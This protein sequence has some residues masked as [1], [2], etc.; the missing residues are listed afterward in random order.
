MDGASPEQPPASERR[1]VD[2]RIRGIVQGVG[3]RPHIW[4][5]AT[6]LSLTGDV[7]ND[8]GGV[9]IR[10]AGTRGSVEALLNSIRTE[11]PHTARI[12][13]IDVRDIDLA[14]TPTGFSIADS[15]SDLAAVTFAP[16]LATCSAC[17]DEIRDPGQRRFRYPFTNCTACGP[18]LTIVEH[19]PYD[20]ANTT[21]RDFP[22]CAAC[23]TEY[24]LP[25]DRRYH[26]EPIACPI[27][28][29]RL[30]LTW[31]DGRLVDQSEISGDAIT[32]AARLLREGHILAIKGLGGFHLACDATLETAIIALRRRKRRVAKPLAVVMRDLAMVER[33]CEVTDIEAACLM[34]PQAPIVLLPKNETPLPEAL[35]PGLKT[36]GVMLPY[37]PLHH[38][39]VEAC[40]R[41]LVMTSAN[42]SDEPQCIDRA[43]VDA[44]L[45]CIVDAS[46]DHDRRIS[47]R[48]DDSVVRIIDGSVALLRRARGYAPAP[49]AMPGAFRQAPTILALGSELKNTVCMLRD[50]VASLSQ[51]IGDLENDLAFDDYLKTLT[52]Q[53]SLH[54]A[55]PAALAIDRHP[56]FLST[57]HGREFAR[58]GGIRLVETQHHHAHIAS[59]LADNGYPPDAG[60][61]LGIV[62]DGLGY[63]DD[64]SLWG[65][66]F[67]LA[68]YGGYQ[69]V[70]S[71]KPVAMLGGAQA[72]REPWRNTYAH[73]I[74][75]V[76]WPEFERICRGTP[77][78][79]LLAAKPLAQLNRMLERGLNSPP[80]SSCGRLFDAVAVA[81]GL[82]QSGIAYEGQ[83]GAEL[84]ALA[85]T[86]LAEV[87]REQSAYSLG[88]N[89][90][91][92]MGRLQ[93]DPGPMW[94]RLSIDLAAGEPPATMAARFHLGFAG[95]VLQLTLTL[96][97]RSESNR[98]EFD[99]VA[100]SGGCFQNKIL[101]E[102]LAAGLRDS[103]MKVL[104]HRHVPANDGGLALGQAAI[105]AWRLVKEWR[106]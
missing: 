65:G 64:G 12:D 54:A 18:R 106:S 15:T 21:M 14:P 93:L 44:R 38:L 103:G 25:N 8:A 4:R 87:T 33:Y 34:S 28:G 85:Q 43:E 2:I 36:L 22:M 98:P 11:P 23:A 29:P 45:A 90:Q 41:P 42:I 74:S 86:K 89:E 48:V 100:L 53:R 66:E 56:E 75:S 10:C 55:A 50:G 80:A 5:V 91:H 105:A 16:D 62:L 78:H 79:G 20:R 26:A 60:P 88:I 68:D 67:L 7:R 3:F 57:K 6:A 40:D 37:T 49:V 1:A 92:G 19:A 61:V 102:T 95:A 96:R 99:T 77:L 82:V 39:L 63:G 35:A 97:A 101:L 72:V 81:V 27:C 30:R 83:S 13:A 73:I 58:A 46:L 76:G 9:L 52:L 70:G 51:H 104:M 31:A 32:T 59:C 84:E 94:R 69:R 24:A 17:L 47:H 71:L